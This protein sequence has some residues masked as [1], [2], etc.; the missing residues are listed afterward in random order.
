MVVSN[1]KAQGALLIKG[2]KIKREKTD[3]LTP[4]KSVTKRQF[5]KV[6]SASLR[7]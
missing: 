3:M 6:Y 1:V 5:I 7:L 4:K 2:V